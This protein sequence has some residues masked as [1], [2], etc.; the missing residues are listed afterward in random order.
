MHRTYLLLFLF[1]MLLHTSSVTASPVV[2]DESR[3]AVYTHGFKVGEV[4]SRYARQGEEGH[5]VVSFTS[6]TRI[7]AAR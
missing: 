5:D 1:V 7:N 4:I 3:L 2:P 6:H